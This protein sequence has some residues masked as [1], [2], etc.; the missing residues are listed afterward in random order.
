MMGQQEKILL[1]VWSVQ[2]LT[3]QFPGPLFNA[4]HS[5][6]GIREALTRAMACIILSALVSGSISLSM[7]NGF[8]CLLGFFL[9]RK[10]LVEKSNISR[11]AAISAC[12]LL[13]IG[14]IQSSRIVDTYQPVLG[15]LMN[16]P[17][18]F[19]VLQAILMVHVFQIPAWLAIITGN[20]EGAQTKFQESWRRE[21]QWVNFAERSLFI[22]S[23]FLGSFLPLGISIILRLIWMF[24]FR[25]DHL[26][27]RLTLAFTGI[28][29]IVISS[30][31]LFSV[32]FL[33]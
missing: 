26:Q 2:I 32:P 27:L 19:Y 14:L 13:C 23:G 28:C 6:G 18:E 12:P 10:D 33:P 4:Q 22:L 8:L 15:N 9:T 25:R 30:R 21:E 29:S 17:Q 20:Q 7:I 16:Y 5:N 31:L 3:W 1:L 11:M 24:I